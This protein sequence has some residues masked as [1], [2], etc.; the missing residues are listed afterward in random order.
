MG[1]H[2]KDGKFF[3]DKYRVIRL[4]PGVEGTDASEDKLVLSFNDPAAREALQLYAGLCDDD[5]L[6]G[7]IIERLDYVTN[8][9]AAE[10][11]KRMAASDMYVAIEATEA[12]DFR[13]DCPECG[14]EGVPE[15]CGECFPKA[16][17]ARLKRRAAL[18]RARGETA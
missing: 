3:S 1:E 4:W 10:A 16:D 8:E 15:T 12:L 6:A 7:D 9:A 5:E 14:G 17:D 18:T 11:W 13:D 2:I